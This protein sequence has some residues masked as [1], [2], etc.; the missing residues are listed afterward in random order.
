MLASKGLQGHQERKAREVSWAC[1]V[2]RDLM[3]QEDT[4]ESQ[5]FPDQK[6]PKVL[7]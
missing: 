7:V 6:E 2:T 5:E 4:E 3:V 1:L